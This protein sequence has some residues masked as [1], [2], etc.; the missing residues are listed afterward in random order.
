MISIF[1]I[2]KA[3][4][5][6]VFLLLSVKSFALPVDWKGTLGMDTTLINNYTRT[7]DDD[8]TIS[9]G[10]QGISKPTDG[11]NDAS[12]QTYIFRLNPT[13][14]V[15]DS[16]TIFT[17]LTTGYGSGGYLG[18]GNEQTGNNTGGSGA[19][20]KNVGN[21]IY[22]Y[23]TYR[24]A[25]NVRQAYAVLYADTATYTI[26]RQS[27]D[28]G[29]GAIL[30]KGRNFTDR[31]ASVEDG[32]KADITIGNFN[33]SPYYMKV[34]T[35][36]NLDKKDDIKHSGISLLYNSVDR[37]LVFGILYSVR[38]V[39]QKSDNLVGTAGVALGS[40]E[41]KMTNIY[42]RKGWGKFNFELEVP[43]LEG[44]LGTVY[45]NTDVAPYK[46]RAFLTKMK[47][48][49]N[50]KWAMQLDGGYVSGDN[51][52]QS[53][54]FEALYLNPNFQVANLLWRY[55][56]YAIDGVNSQQNIWD[57]YITNAQYAKLTGIYSSEKWTWKLGVLYAKAI[58]TATSGF[59]AFNHEKNT[60]FNANFDQ[61]DDLGIEIDADFVYQWNTNVAINGSLGY[62]MVG[63]Y[64]KFTNTATDQNIKDSYAGQLQAIIAF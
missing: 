43:I 6:L 19:A 32:I 3:L 11:V 61:S 38:K 58:E 37:D 34:D 9:N 64:F 4:A 7:G 56:L 30:N 24:D 48:D 20:G 62:H 16:A 55:N 35:G 13:I 63:D 41:V 17:E 49:L 53:R 40:A 27:L 50:A 59:S 2:F 46:A 44:D 14:I 36:A 15:N 39:R 47:Y 51:G 25:L 10:S 45:T 57:S 29:M 42:V 12:F 23:N 1:P 60:V 8:P 54:N 18:Q 33:I 5:C 22:N 28:W 31:H 26:G 21:V 52:Q